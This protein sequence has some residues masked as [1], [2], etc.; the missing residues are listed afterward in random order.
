MLPSFS[1]TYSIIELRK[2]GKLS[3]RIGDPVEPYVSFSDICDEVQ[4]SWTFSTGF[5]CV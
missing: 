4:T 2:V 1:V 5:P 3:W